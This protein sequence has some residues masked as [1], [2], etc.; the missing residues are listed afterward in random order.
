M[1]ANPP[2]NFNP[3]ITVPIKQ[4]RSTSHEWYFLLVSGEELLA[5]HLINRIHLLTLHNMHLGTQK[6]AVCTKKSDRCQRVVST[7]PIRGSS[8]KCD[9]LVDNQTKCPA[10]TKH[11]LSQTERLISRLKGS[12]C[13][14]M[15]LFV[16]D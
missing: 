14:F 16:R 2:G 9:H 5:D 1:I 12:S 13:S 10:T 15:L 11:L 8:S 3:C 4:G 7:Q 6:T